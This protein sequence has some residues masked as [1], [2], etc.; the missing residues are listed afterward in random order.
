MTDP[1]NSKG[2]LGIG[3]GGDFRIH[4]ERRL[5]HPP[6]RVWQWLTVQEKLERWLPGCEI[7]AVL[8]GRVRFDFGDEGAATGEVLQVEEPAVLEHTWT[9]QG[10]PDSRVTWLLTPHEEG[11]LL[12]LVHREVMREPAKEFAV[13]WHV[14]L[15][16]LALDLAG[17]S[18][19][20][21][22]A[23]LEHVSSL[24]ST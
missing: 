10:M 13:G 23:A 22:W 2:T 21:A 12:T 14:M 24:Y 7:D 9:W 1:A 20:D 5:P 17:R 6:E 4:F 15:D 16:A 3:D 11:T 18:T 8:G 19:D